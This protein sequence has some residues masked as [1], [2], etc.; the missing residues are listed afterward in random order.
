MKPSPYA[1]FLLICLTAPLLSASR[2]PTE[3]QRI[4]EWHENGYTWPPKWQPETEE[5][6]RFYDARER[7]I[8]SIPGGQE[9]WANW[10]Q[11]TQSRM[12]PTFTP[13]GFH[14]R[15]TPESIQKRLYDATMKG[16]GDWD[17]IRSEGSI[18]VIYHPADSPPKFIDL[19]NI[20]LYFF[21][22]F[23]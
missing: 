14:L 17:G 16:L 6:K 7:E 5:M 15:K 21:L 12:L 1:V 22:Q 18:D 23:S 3:E 10:L 8:M 20:E 13:T 11:F 4:K 9:R 19:G 2:V